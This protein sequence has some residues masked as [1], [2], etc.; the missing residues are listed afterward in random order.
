M[1]EPLLIAVL[2]SSTMKRTNMVKY[3]GWCKGKNIAYRKQEGYIYL[4]EL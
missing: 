4:G 3:W 1:E 2:R